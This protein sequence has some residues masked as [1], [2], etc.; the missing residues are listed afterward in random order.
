[1]FLGDHV[2]LIIRES[3]LELLDF[4]NTTGTIGNTCRLVE[5][6][7]MVCW[8]ALFNVDMTSDTP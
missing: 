1:M 3:S 2:E 5:L 7:G 6:A 8:K 4:R